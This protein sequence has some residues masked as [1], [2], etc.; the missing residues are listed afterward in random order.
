MKRIAPVMTLV[1]PAR[2]GPEVPIGGPPL[3]WRSI[4][5]LAVAALLIG[6]RNSL[7]VT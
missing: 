4:A 6:L 7:P 5:L 3:E 1:D 2:N